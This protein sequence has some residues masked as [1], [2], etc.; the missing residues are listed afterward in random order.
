M[1]QFTGDF[2]T[3][4]TGREGRVRSAGKSKEEG[5]FLLLTLNA[6][7]HGRRVTLDRGRLAQILA[8]GLVLLTSPLE[9][10][11][12]GG[13][14][15]LHEAARTARVEMALASFFWLAKSNRWVGSSWISYCNRKQIF[16]T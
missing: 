16:V 10:V 11:D 8:V 5:G 12:M 3:G 15:G 4:E 9:R 7:G 14:Y 2:E 6:L 13:G 1:E